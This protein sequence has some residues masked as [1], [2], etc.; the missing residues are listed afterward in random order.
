MLLV[1]CALVHGY[2]LIAAYGS[3]F[4]LE[5]YRQ[6]AY[7]VTHGL[8]VYDYTARYPYPPVWIWVVGA[9]AEIAPWFG[10]PFHVMIKVPGSIGDLAI[11]LL[12]FH[13]VRARDGW[14]L[15]ALG[16]AALY[17]LNPIPALVSAAHGQF[18]S[19]PVFF[20]LL[21]FH[22]RDRESKGAVE[23]A[24]VSLG[25]G[26]ALKAYPALLVPFLALTAPQGRRVTTLGICA[27]PV[28]IAMA[29]YAAVA[30][31]S[32]AMLSHVVGY[33]STTA[34]GW[35]IF[36][37]GSVL[38]A[39]LVIVAW[40]ASDLVTM[41][42]AALGPWLLFRRRAVPGAA[43]IFALFLLIAPQASV[44]Y[45]IWGLPFFCLMTAAG[46]IV[47]SAV[48]AVMMFAF[49]ATRE[50]SVLP[51]SVPAPMVGSLVSSYATIAALVI[52]ASLMM[53]AIA[54][55]RAQLPRRES[56]L[57]SMTAS[58]TVV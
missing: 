43:A 57:S 7:A 27:A 51:V 47:Y 10:M 23:L 18:D 5:S 48:G 17:A 20:T 46:T 55:T 1:A 52:A 31:Y 12:L 11:V 40:I 14:V 25:V 41:V 26:I 50:P 44:Q 9:I 54:L 15:H 39:T 56:T 58:A 22:L 24:A 16:P 42:F 32:P 36:T 53:L 6:Q 34:M 3:D 49:Y 4:D 2:L 8:N 21:A 33:L 30:G 29:I 37:S 19:L 38:P 45:L 13:Y 35:R 28:L